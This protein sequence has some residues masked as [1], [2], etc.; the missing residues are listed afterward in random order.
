MSLGGLV[1]QVCMG[2]AALD[3]DFCLSSSDQRSAAQL[4]RLV[5]HRICSVLQEWCEVQALLTT[6]GPPVRAACEPGGE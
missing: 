6:D 1:V 4:S 2:T 5:R 3:A